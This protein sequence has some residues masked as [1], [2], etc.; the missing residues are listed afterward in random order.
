MDFDGRMFPEYTL[1]L[2]L[3]VLATKPEPPSAWED[4]QL[5]ASESRSQQYKT[6]AAALLPIIPL[7]LG[8]WVVGPILPSTANT[9]EC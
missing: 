9:S 8:G 1:I 2:G 3:D 5:H 4:P 6:R 7:T